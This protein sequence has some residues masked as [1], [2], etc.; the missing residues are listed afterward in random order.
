MTGLQNVVTRVLRRQRLTSV[1]AS[2][3]ARWL[4]SLAVI[5]GQHLRSLHMSRSLPTGRA[6]RARGPGRGSGVNAHMNE[7][8][9]GAGL[10]P[11]RAFTRRFSR[12]VPY[13]SASPPG[14]QNLMTSGGAGPR[15][16]EPR[17]HHCILRLMAVARRRRNRP[18]P[19]DPSSPRHSHQQ[20][21]RSAPHRHW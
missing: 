5:S 4:A 2:G 8:A 1:A 12:P 3:A 20:T 18:S 19:R 16:Q 13:H 21:P 7:T 11:A 17:H 14:E 15:R 6:N 9:E 10:E